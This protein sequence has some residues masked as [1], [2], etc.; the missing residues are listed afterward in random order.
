MPRR[1]STRSAMPIEQIPL[2][3]EL[4]FRIGLDGCARPTAAPTAIAKR[5]ASTPRQGF[6]APGCARP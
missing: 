6:A 2:H 1:S 5:M 4:R 3:C